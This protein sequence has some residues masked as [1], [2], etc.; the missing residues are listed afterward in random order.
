M[1]ILIRLLSCVVIASAVIIVWTR[2]TLV[3][4]F[5]PA[6]TAVCLWIAA[7]GSLCAVITLVWTRK[8]NRPEWYRPPEAP[9][10]HLVRRDHDRAGWRS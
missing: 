1:R 6:L 2:A 7:G 10:A 3:Y 5:G 4:V 8:P 9:P